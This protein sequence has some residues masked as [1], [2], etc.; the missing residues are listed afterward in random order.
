MCTIVRALMDVGALFK[1]NM[2]EAEAETESVMCSPV[3]C[4]P[5]KIK[6]LAI[7]RI[8]SRNGKTR[9]LRDKLQN[10]PCRCM[11]HR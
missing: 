3:T 9:E 5:L 10:V 1:T 4:L 11:L 6:R 2:A 8:L 7:L